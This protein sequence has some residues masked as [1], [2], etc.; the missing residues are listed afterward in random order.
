MKTQNVLNT[1]FIFCLLQAIDREIT[2]KQSRVQDTLGAAE[3]LIEQTS[4]PRQQARLESQAN[5]LKQRFDDLSARSA[6]RVEVLEEALPQ[7]LQFNESHEELTK[8]LDE[9]EGD[10]KNL[11]PPGLDA[12]EIRREVDNNRVSHLWPMM[13][14]QFEILLIMI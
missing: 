10:L 9:V 8:W 13:T 2:G 5:D 1:Y 14:Y 7:T 11:K 3:A 12:E 6:D 4:D